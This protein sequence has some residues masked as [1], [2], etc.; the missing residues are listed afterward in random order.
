VDQSGEIIGSAVEKFA[1]DMTNLAISKAKDHANAQ[2]AI[3]GAQAGV[4]RDASGKLIAPDLTDIDPTSFYGSA[5]L[6]KSSEVFSQSVRNDA[7]KEADVL[8][9]ENPNDVAQY[10]AR[11]AA[12]RDTVLEGVP[13]ELLPQAIIDIDSIH[14]SKRAGVLAAQAQFA[15]QALVD[16]HN[17]DQDGLEQQL[18]DH[19]QS[20]ADDP[21]M[22]D[23]LVGQYNANNR[24]MVEARMMTEAE[25]LSAE[26]ALSDRMD[27]EL[28]TTA[29]RAFLIENDL[30]GFSKLQEEI[31]F[32][33]SLA[34]GVRANALNTL[35]AEL[36]QWQQRDNRIK[37]KSAAA[38][39]KRQ[40]EAQTAE[41]A[42]LTS[43][44]EM[45][46]AAEYIA[47]AE[48]GK[49]SRGFGHKMALAT[50]DASQAAIASSNQRVV[51]AALENFENNFIKSMPLDI[52]AIMTDA[53]HKRYVGLL[54]SKKKAQMDG[55]QK[56]S[57]NDLKNAVTL[58]P[59]LYDY[60]VLREDLDARV[61]SGEITAD[62]AIDIG[63]ALIQATI[64][65]AKANKHITAAKWKLENRSPI[66]L[67]NQE[68]GAIE[69]A[70]PERYNVLDVA[71]HPGIVSLSTNAR[72]VPPGV[73]NFIKSAPSQSGDSLDALFKLFN[74]YRESV[75][76]DYL[77]VNLLKGD[78]K[79]V[80]DAAEIYRATGD[81]KVAQTLMV[82][83]AGG[84]NSASS[85][86]LN[87]VVPDGETPQGRR[88]RYAEASS[89][90]IAGEAG[91]FDTIL[92]TWFGI[93]HNPQI[94]ADVNDFDTRNINIEDFPV[95]GGAVDFVADQG[96]RYIMAGITSSLQTAAEIATH[97]MLQIYTPVQIEDGTYEW[98]QGDINKTA[99]ND[100]ETPTIIKDRWTGKIPLED[101][102]IRATA[103][104]IP[105]PTGAGWGNEILDLIVVPGTEGHEQ[106]T[107]TV[108]YKLNDQWHPMD[109]QLDDGRRV[110]VHYQWDYPS[111]G[112]KAMFDIHVDK[113]QNGTFF[114]R[115]ENFA[116]GDNE[117]WF[118]IIDSGPVQEGQ[119]IIATGEAQENAEYWRDI[120]NYVR[121][122]NVLFHPEEQRQIINA[123]IAVTGK[124]K[125]VRTTVIDEYD[126][127][128]INFVRSK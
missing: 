52:Q 54:A 83:S 116:R 105:S 119:R 69:S 11:F 57:V 68:I 5:F 34:E 48:S 71:K 72:N 89:G 102:R 39:T 110:P 56:M 98:R 78:Y 60:N 118:G 73:A 111:S 100:P 114:E 8:A 22:A 81:I 122:G 97:D 79:P 20:G 6:N 53:D 18:T 49:W 107:Y 117:G 123:P 82:N 62:Q 76:G 37:A 26:K 94:N 101:I 106:P 93:S 95:N 21:L 7:R 91:W 92:G 67:S 31:Q 121:L 17:A 42:R 65:E 25:A 27:T 19:I 29:G 46:T 87:A 23:Y 113:G 61:A 90:V 35:N 80:K 43:G 2:G 109:V 50:H 13:E 70:D 99:M 112:L 3:D 127:A 1:T 128:L 86:A 40:N 16:E 41:I 45:L 28:F 32:D 58:N 115:L 24:R 74:T 38:L 36:N 75:A 84:D 9:A 15:A 51:N 77:M 125:K 85:R 30:Q 108:R 96:D 126:G 120:L 4:A 33:A 44:E 12:Y 55:L 66:P 47:G 104:N 59:S 63:D 103:H 10:D 64:K 124:P 88:D 14:A